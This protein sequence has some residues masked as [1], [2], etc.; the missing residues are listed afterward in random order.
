MLSVVFELVKFALKLKARYQ[1][2]FKH[3]ILRLA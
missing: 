3:L 1:S 2:Q